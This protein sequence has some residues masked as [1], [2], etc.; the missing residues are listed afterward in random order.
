MFDP[1]SF[2]GREEQLTTDTHALTREQLL[3]YANVATRIR[4]DL[5]R[6]AGELGGQPE[7]QAIGR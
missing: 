7:S 1:E 4:N 2:R 3:G 6:K 5:R